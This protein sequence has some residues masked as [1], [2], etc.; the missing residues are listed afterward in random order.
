MQFLSV[1]LPQ[2]YPLS[3]CHFVAAHIQ[4]TGCVKKYPNT[5]IAISH[6]CVDIYAP[7]FDHLFRTK[8]R[9]SVLLRAVFTTALTS[10]MNF[11][12]ER[13]VGFIK[14]TRG[15][16]TTFVETSLWQS[17]LCTK[18]ILPLHKF[19][20]FAIFVGVFFSE[21]PCS[22]WQSFFSTQSIISMS[23]S[24]SYRR[25]RSL[26]LSRHRSLRMPAKN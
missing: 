16:T 9:L 20:N 6:K 14:V 7:N 25:N 4:G 19:V 2:A 22:W 13:K 11:A 23:H 10:R 1:V 15:A 17:I 12:T 18:N 3:S 26:I 8:L 21:S 24:K 5:K